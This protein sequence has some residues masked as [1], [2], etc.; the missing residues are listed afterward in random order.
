MSVGATLRQAREAKGLSLEDI[1]NSTQIMTRQLQEMEADDF[2]SFAAPIYAKGFIRLFAR[3]VGID[4]A[5]LVSEFAGQPMKPDSAAPAPKPVAAAPAA[6]APTP[7]AP[8]APAEPAP[9]PQPAP[10]SAPDDLFALAAQPRSDAPAPPPAPQPAAPVPAKATAKVVDARP[11]AFELRT[12]P[13]PQ[14][15]KRVAA[16]EPGVPAPAPPP[17]SRVEPRPGERAE[18]IPPPAAK[19]LP[20][21]ASAAW[22]GAA[23][24]GDGRP[25]APDPL[26]LEGPAFRFP[27]P[28]PLPRPEPS[29]APAPVAAAPAPAFRPAPAP[30]PAPSAAAPAPAAAPAKATEAPSPLQPRQRRNVSALPDEEIV[31]HAAPARKPPAAPPADEDEALFAERAPKRRRKPRPDAPNAASLFLANLRASLRRGFAGRRLRLV[32]GAA[33]LAVLLVAG[34]VWISAG[35]GET[36]KPAAPEPVLPAPEPVLATAAPAA[37]AEPAGQ[38]APAEPPETIAQVFP[39]PFSWAK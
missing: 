19:K 35:R 4:P 26:P 11:L 6:P 22:R 16:L 20:E 5:P 8:A 10:E 36:D 13:K 31:A 17:E 30:A 21:P 39:P 15:V 24:S 28:R 23:L 27:E 38:T 18:F 9:A 37:D 33:A 25:V 7:A 1:K 2:S 32:A 3:A 12:A 34:G 14:P 29:A